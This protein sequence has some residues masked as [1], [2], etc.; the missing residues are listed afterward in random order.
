M[1]E[2]PIFVPYGDD[3]IAGI[4]TVPE[5]TPRGVVLML[6][7]QGASSRAHKYRLW[8]RI[9]HRLATR[10]IGTLRIDLPGMGES[11]GAPPGSVDDLPTAQAAVMLEMAM[12]ALGV[13]AF[14]LAG[15]CYG[16]EAVFDLAGDERCKGVAFI[17]FADP[18]YII[19]EEH[20][21][22]AKPP[23]PKGLGQPAWKRLAR[24]LPVTRLLA[25]EV[26]KRRARKR[27][28]PVEFKNLVESTATLFLQLRPERRASEIARAIRQLQPGP[29]APIAVRSISHSGAL[30][31][32]PRAIQEAVIAEMADW[33]DQTLPPAPA[34]AERE[35]HVPATAT[36]E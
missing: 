27:P 35:S 11:T 26:R 23:V 2:H 12:R 10:G 14:V 33:F 16:A 25:A 17:L 22:G 34:P 31:R 1:T 3:V 9:A 13:D 21:P 24:R 32:M 8:V 5:G 7:G 15:H 30:T 19:A 18:R 20:A 6:Q 28:W 36:A 29:N 4:V